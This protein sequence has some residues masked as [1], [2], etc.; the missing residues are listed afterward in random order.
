MRPFIMT[1]SGEDFWFLN[2]SLE[3]IKIEDIASALS[4]ICRYTGHCRHFY[5]VAQH[6]VIVSHL[7]PEEQ[8]LEGLLHDASEAYLGDMSAP[9][10]RKLP[11]YQAIEE[12]VESA[13]AAK[14]GLMYNI[15]LG[16]PSAVKKADIAVLALEK[17]LLL[18]ESK[19]PWSIL[20]GVEC[21]DE[22]LLHHCWQ[23]LVAELRFLQ[24]YNELTSSS[25]AAP[26]DEP[27]AQSC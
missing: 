13:I 19:T 12:V 4:K 9:L 2:P 20:E 25:I 22:K 14:F 11:E 18:P 26:R 10:K 7:V 17:K 21:P 1:A 15:E 24:R 27:V 23:P 16:W 6:S 8:A 3:T 5:S